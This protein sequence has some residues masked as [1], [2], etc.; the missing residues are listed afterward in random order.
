MEFPF[1]SGILRAQGKYEESYNIALEG[2]QL[3]ESVPAGIISACFYYYVAI[4]QKHILQQRGEAG[5]SSWIKKAALDN[6]IKALQHSQ[7][8]SVEQEFSATIADLRQRIHVLRAITILGD[9]VNGKDFRAATPSDIKAAETDLIA[10][11]CMV[12][13]GHIATNYH[14]IC[15]LFA[16]SDFHVCQWGQQ[17]NTKE[18][19]SSEIETPDLLNGAFNLATEAKALSMKFHFQ[20]L[21]NYANKRLAVITEIII[22]HKVS[23]LGPRCKN[24]W[25]TVAAI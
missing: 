17:Q 21:T 9:F 25:S 1:K 5:R 7:A 24:A 3:L 14:R 11:H 23:S 18:E 15:Y 20:E 12:I 13:D 4:L 10:Y 8:S 22:K 6:F 16:M 2:L 19:R